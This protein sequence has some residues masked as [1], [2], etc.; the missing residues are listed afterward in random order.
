VCVTGSLFTV[1]EARIYFKHQKATREM[2]Q[3]R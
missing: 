3:D 2:R 1:S